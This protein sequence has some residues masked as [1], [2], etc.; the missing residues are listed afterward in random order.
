V[1]ALVQTRRRRIAY[2]T[3]TFAAAFVI[4]IPLVMF[5]GSVILEFVLSRW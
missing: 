2:W 5:V 1:R 4:G 3:I